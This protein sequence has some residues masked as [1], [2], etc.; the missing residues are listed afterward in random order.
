MTNT[1]A[2]AD[3]HFGGEKKCVL[4]YTQNALFL[5]YYTCRDERF[6]TEEERVESARWIF[7][8]TQLHMYM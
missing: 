4:R 7:Q 2:A 5:L 8:P 1:A 6:S 3:E